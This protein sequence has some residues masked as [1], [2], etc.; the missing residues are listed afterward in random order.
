[1]TAELAPFRANE[2]YKWEP[3]QPGLEDV[4]IHLMRNAKDESAADKT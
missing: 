4:F 2:R 3:V 1:M